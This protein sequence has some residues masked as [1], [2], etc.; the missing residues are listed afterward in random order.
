MASLMITGGKIGQVWGRK[1]VFTIGCM[2]YGCGSLLT[3]LSQNLT[4][5]LIGWSLLEGIGAALIMPAVV[6]L[7]ASKGLSVPGLRPGRFRRRDR[8]GCRASHR[9]AAHH[10]RVVAVGFRRRGAG[11]SDH[12]RV[13]PAD[14]RHTRRPP[15]RPPRGWSPPPDRLIPWEDV[16]ASSGVD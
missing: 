5:L 6:A 14:G 1:R 13:G 10:L 11:R 9:R 3:A 4:M 2:I 7:V 16:G 15:R 8:S 12:P